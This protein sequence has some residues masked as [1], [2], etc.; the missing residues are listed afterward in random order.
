MEVLSMSE[1]SIS[2]QTHRSLSGKSALML[3]GGSSSGRWNWRSSN[4]LR[5]C[6]MKSGRPSPW[7]ESPIMSYL[8][9]LTSPFHE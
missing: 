2:L 3:Y 4:G 8:N 6:G 5:T 7:P 9:S 1:R